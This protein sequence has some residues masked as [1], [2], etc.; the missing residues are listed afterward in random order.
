[1]NNQIKNLL[2]FIYVFIFK[3]LPIVD[4]EIRKTFQFLH[5][6]FSLECKIE[7]NP[8]ERLY[9]LKNGIIYDAQLN[10]NQE[11]NRHTERSVMHE[12]SRVRVDKYDMSNEN[13]FYKILLTLT[14]MVNLEE[15]KKIFFN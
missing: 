3:V 10:D 12:S 14:I 13:E 15:K 2:F 11:I 1:M 9:W 8:I 5:K 4:L 7:A 6:K